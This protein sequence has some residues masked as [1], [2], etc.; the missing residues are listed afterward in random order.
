MGSFLCIKPWIVGSLPFCGS[1]Q[2]V[3]SS[4]SGTVVG[5]RHSELY[6]T[7]SKGLEP[8]TGD[9]KSPFAGVTGTTRTTWPCVIFGVF[10]ICSSALDQLTV[11][12]LATER[13]PDGLMTQA[14]SKNGH[15][16]SSDQLQTEANILLSAC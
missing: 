2:A 5:S 10:I 1:D 9:A 3:T 16:V 13:D 11:A 7:A 8:I 6:T 4:S 12:H 15:W 14:D